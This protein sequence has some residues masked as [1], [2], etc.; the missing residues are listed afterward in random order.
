MRAIYSIKHL[1]D[2]NQHAHPVMNL[3]R[4]REKM[5]ILKILTAWSIFFIDG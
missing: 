3:K 2:L 5:G 4:I 1:R